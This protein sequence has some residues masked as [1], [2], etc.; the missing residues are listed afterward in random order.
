MTSKFYMY[1]VLVN[2]FLAFVNMWITKSDGTALINLISAAIC[3]I[4]YNG[5]KRRENE[6]ERDKRKD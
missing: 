1:A 3:Y 6:T 5:F 4:A 2:C